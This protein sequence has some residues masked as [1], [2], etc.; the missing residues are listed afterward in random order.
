MESKTWN[1]L[2]WRVWFLGCCSALPC[3]CLLRNLCNDLEVILA[4]K[5]WT[6][7][8]GIMSGPSSHV[9]EWG[10]KT[11]AMGRK[12]RVCLFAAAAC[13]GDRCLA[14]HVAYVIRIR[15]FWTANFEGVWIFFIK[16]LWVGF[17]TKH[18]DILLYKPS[19]LMMFI[20]TIGSC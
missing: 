13:Y 17:A 7:P 18:L 12:V 8:S 19:C 2:L 1:Q 15:V 16:C 20:A 9:G 11:Q 5:W 4:A 3:V 14:R 10:E 6:R